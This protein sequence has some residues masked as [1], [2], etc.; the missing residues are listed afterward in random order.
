LHAFSLG[1]DKCF[2]V[3]RI[4]VPRTDDYG[5]IGGNRVSTA[6]ENSSWQVSESL[7]ATY[8]FPTESLATTGGLGIPD[9]YFAARG[10]GGGRTLE[11]ASG[12]IT[13]PLHPIKFVP[14]EG[15]Y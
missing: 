7:H 14:A 9:N 11:G 13:E 6:T 15:F 2:V 8:S 12:K 3:W 10:Y 5:A 1:P 4:R